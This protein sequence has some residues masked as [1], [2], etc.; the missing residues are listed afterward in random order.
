MRSL[1]EFYKW[2]IGAMRN[3]DGIGELS[4]VVF[5]FACSQ[6]SVL[7]L[8]GMY[9]FLWFV[10]A[11][12]ALGITF[13]AVGLYVALFLGVFSK[14]TVKRRKPYSD[15]VVVERHGFKGLLYN[16]LLTSEALKEL[17]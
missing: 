13:V 2:W 7:G 8:I 11:K 5:V 9:V 16:V 14:P 10:E 3:C 1:I 15:E 6:V 4:M 12:V 17:G